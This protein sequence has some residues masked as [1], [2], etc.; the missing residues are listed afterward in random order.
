MKILINRPLHLSMLKSEVLD[1]MD[2]MKRYAV[3]GKVYGT[4]EHQTVTITDQ[5]ITLDEDSMREVILAL[6][7]ASD[8]P[9]VL[10]YTGYDFT[11][12]LRKKI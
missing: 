12:E 10:E 1:F 6:D 3:C 2:L 7:A 9:L 4:G 8:C 5:K 11:F